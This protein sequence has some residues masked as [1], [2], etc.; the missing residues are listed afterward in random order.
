MRTLG[1]PAYIGK[2][3]EIVRSCQLKASG[4]AFARLGAL[5][6]DNTFGSSVGWHLGSGHELHPN[7][8]GRAPRDSRPPMERIREFQHEMLWQ[9]V[10][11]A[12]FEPHSTLR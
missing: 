6:M 8:I 5:D 2:R 9:A 1:E 12:D 3:A 11:T 10:G 7:L 4:Y